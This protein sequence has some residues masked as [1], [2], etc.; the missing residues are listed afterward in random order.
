[1]KRLLINEINKCL[2]LLAIFQEG[3]FKIMFIGLNVMEKYLPY[4]ET[5]HSEYLF[6]Y[7]IYILFTIKLVYLIIPFTNTFIFNYIVGQ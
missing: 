3:A 4:F 2:H 1:M 5:V 6:L 7:S